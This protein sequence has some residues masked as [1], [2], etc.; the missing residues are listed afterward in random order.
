MKV[1]ILNE[2]PWIADTTCPHCGITFDA[3]ARVETWPYAKP[4]LKNIINTFMKYRLYAMECPS[5]A[6]SMI[7]DAKHHRTYKYDSQILKKIP[8]NVQKFLVQTKP[9]L[10]KTIKHQFDNHFNMSKIYNVSEKI[11][12][13]DFCE[14]CRLDDIMY[15]IPD[16][17][18]NKV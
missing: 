13:K 11:C 1:Q 10:S 14:I 18:P 8:V 9:P 2:M 7:H 3:D 12:F 6:S 17:I 5:C 16:I 15:H 4:E